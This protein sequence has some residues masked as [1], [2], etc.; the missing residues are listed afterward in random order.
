M[1]D[2]DAVA[3]PGS[4]DATGRDLRAQALELLR[5]PAHRGPLIASGAVVLTLG[6]ALEELRLA[7]KLPTG[8]HLVILALAAAVMVGL[9]LRFGPEGGRAPAFLSVLLVCGL[10]LLYAALLTLANVLGADFDRFSPGAFVWTSAA[11]GA[12]AA[13][14]SIHKASAIC[15]LI[16]AVA[17]GVAVL[18]AWD[19]LFDLDGLAP[20][21]WL[22]A[23]MALAL[24]LISLVARGGWPRHAEQL[25]N[26]AGLAVLAIGLTGVARVL[27]A[28]LSPFGSAPPS[29]LPGV[30]EVVLVAAGCGLIAYGAIDRAPGAAWLGV[31]NLLTFTVAV[32]AGADETLAWWPLLL[33]MLGIGTMA[34][35]LRP[36]APLPPEPR[37]YRVDDTPLAARSAERLGGESLWDD[38]T[39][40]RVRDDGPAR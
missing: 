35:G 21:R 37:A 19:W 23:L 18:S 39:V 20:I 2:V 36:R 38:T 28:A 1:P 8:V 24:V 32:T 27:V 9:A 15:A 22:L 17:L 31:A 16:A 13:W 14:A 10:G 3:T 33:L 6:I 12:L 30:W 40:I 5:P 7:D 26:A 34:A 29:P 25:V 4:G 11:V